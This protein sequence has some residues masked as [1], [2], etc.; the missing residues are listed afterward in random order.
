MR[1]SLATCLVPA[2]PVAQLSSAPSRPKQRGGLIGHGGL[3]LL[4]G[5]RAEPYPELVLGRS[6]DVQRDRRLGGVG[7]WTGARREVLIDVVDDDS[8]E[9]PCFERQVA[10]AEVLAA[11]A[12]AASGAVAQS[13]STPASV[14]ADGRRDPS[15]FPP[16]LGLDVYGQGPPSRAAYSRRSGSSITRPPR[17]WVKKLNAQRISTRRRF[18][19]PIRYQR[20]T[21][22][23]VTQAGKPLSRIV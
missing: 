1:P 5:S 2:A 13:R 7:L 11:H 16:G 15:V 22:T 18:W 8:Q 23:Q 21:T 14:A 3:L 17:P 19:K 20:W 9:V 4:R 6:R 10:V 12:L